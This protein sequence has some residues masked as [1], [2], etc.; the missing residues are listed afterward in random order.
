MSVEAIAPIGADAAATTAIPSSRPASDFLEIVSTQVAGVDASL[1]TAETH[2][3]QL[4]AGRDIAV[5]DVMIAM[6]E[7]RT[8]LLLLVEVRNR[9]IE[10]YQ[11]LTRMQL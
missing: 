9:V 3:A 6:E 11:E 2:L 5:H 1:R 4:A 10:A 7:A 8:N